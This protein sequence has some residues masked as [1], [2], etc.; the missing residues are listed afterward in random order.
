MRAIM[1]NK[2]FNRIIKVQKT[3]KIERL[4]GILPLLG[5][6]LFLFSGLFSDFVLATANDV[7][8]LLGAA[9][10]DL[11]T[12]IKDHATVYVYGAEAIAAAIA[13]IKTRNITVFIG[14]LALSLFFTKLVFSL[15]S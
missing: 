10:T 3:L 14:L 9:K 1:F 5:M 8:A 7:P 15:I 11:V 4:K 6:G 2:L 12:G 13:Y